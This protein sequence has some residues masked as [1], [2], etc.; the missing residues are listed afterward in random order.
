ME[1]KIVIKNIIHLLES[2]ETNLGNAFVKTSSIGSLKSSIISARAHNLENE[3]NLYIAL[4][5]SL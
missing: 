2:I 5:S 4:A 1:F 3:E